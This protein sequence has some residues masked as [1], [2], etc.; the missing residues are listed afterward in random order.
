MS[1]F[2]VENCVTSVDKQEELREF[3]KE[4]TKIFAEAQLDLRL[5][6]FTIL[7]PTYEEKHMSSVLGMI[8]NRD[9]DTLHLCLEN[10]KQV[11]TS[12][13]T[14]R[15][16]LSVTKKI[17]D[18]VGFGLPVLLQPKML[19]NCQDIPTHFWTDST[20]VL[21]WIKSTENWKSFV[22]NRIEADQRCRL[23]PG[24]MN[25]ADLPS[26]GCRVS[27]FLGSW[28]WEGLN[29][30]KEETILATTE[31]RHDEDKV[32]EERKKIVTTML[33]PKKN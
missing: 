29:W 15:L 22:W 21:S 7:Y 4:A 1:S 16:I 12:C 2:Y 20:A 19:F 17:F 5:W 31:L 10:L 3:I 9:D 18:Q 24:T 33:S 6:K 26:R 27:R 11:D 14:K 28:W 8:W 13:I 25:P 30:L 23:V 32:M